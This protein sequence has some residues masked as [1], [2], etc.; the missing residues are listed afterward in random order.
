M[1]P[2]LGVKRWLLLMLIGTLLIGFSLA[3]MLAA[4]GFAAWLFL[5]RSPSIWPVIGFLFIG[6]GL[7]VAGGFLAL[8]RTLIDVA[9]RTVAPDTPRPDNREVVKTLLARSHPP[10]MPLKIVA[11]GGG[12]GM[13]QLLRG[14]RA[15]TDDITAIVTVADDGGSSGRLRRQMGMLPPG[16]FRNNIAAL[17]EAEELMTRL[18]QYRFAAGDVAGISELAGHSF[19]NLF[20]ATMAAV[21][22][23]FE[24]GIAESSR[25]LAVRGRILPSTLE[26]VTLCAEIARPL[27]GEG[28]AR[29]EWIIVEGESN[30]P[31]AGGR[32]L[33]VFLKPDAVRAYPAVVQAI[34][35]ADLIVAGPGS[36]FTS[37]MPNLLV[38]EVR[39]AIAAASA[40]SVYVCNVATQPGETDD[41]TVSD[42]MRHMRLHAGNIFT[43][44]LANNAYDSERPP[45]PGGQWVTL[46]GAEEPLAYRLFSADLISERFPSHHDPAKVAARLME[47]YA[48]LQKE[49]GAES[50]LAGKEPRA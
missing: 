4:R 22:G 43:T 41:F 45:Y 21:S 23:S 33:R 3:L 38:P 30:I 37:V 27:S 34:L 26:H 2:G 7:L 13:P 42:H 47:V 17:S 40:P 48:R 29:E 28:G 35:Q 15:Y 20:I 36:F 44:V 10:E 8:N 9:V 50:S 49:G 24:A 5:W 14:L 1:R 46:P 19:G 31:E 16:D 18:F 11:I 39:D 25:V 6:G 32:I 12:T